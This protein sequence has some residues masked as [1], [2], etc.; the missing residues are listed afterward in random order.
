M[1]IRERLWSAAYQVA[2]T[3]VCLVRLPRLA[4]S[5]RAHRLYESFDSYQWR[6]QEASDI[7][8]SVIW[9]HAPAAGEALTA[10][11]LIRG[12]IRR[13]P[14]SRCVLTVT[15]TSGFE[16]G[17][18]A[19][20]EGVPLCL[21][22]LPPDIGWL[23]RRVIG[24]IAPS[25]VVLCQGIPKRPQLLHEFHARHISVIWV[26][27]RFQ[28]KQVAAWR[29][30]PAALRIAALRSITECLVTSNEAAVAFRS[31]CPGPLR[32][33]V[34]GD[35]ASSQSEEA[36]T[37]HNERPSA[38]G[39]GTE[40][41]GVIVAGSTHPG[42]ELMLL[43]A[44][45]ALRETMGDIQLIV[46]P[47]HVQRS[48]VIAELARSHGWKTELLTAWDRG[49]S[50]DVVVVDTMGELRHLYGTATLA[51]VGGTWVPKG[52]HNLMEPAVKGCPVLFGPYHDHWRE[53]AA[54]LLESG[55]GLCVETVDAFVHQASLLLSDPSLR[56]SMSAAACSVAESSGEAS[57]RYVE[58]I[59]EAAQG[60]GVGSHAVRGR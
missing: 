6:G 9:I 37:D 14:G 51:F 60:S 33:S 43:Q 26:N 34:V 41:L 55:G 52:G 31:L 13:S 44:F 15:S 23:N 20:D 10:V 18:R 49:R 28:E 1:S 45:Q 12:L 58:A 59:L 39:T 27:G 36:T 22:R 11:S 7:S 25:V 50:V 53:A 8:D 19:Q 24:R 35:I 57:E 3:A 29:R 38:E 17:R 48:M 42:E 54:A 32:I 56:E 2:L 30:F 47:R 5:H 21:L 46:A 40:T 16:M 4:W